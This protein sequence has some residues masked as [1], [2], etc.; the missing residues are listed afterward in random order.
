MIEVDIDDD[1]QIGRDLNPLKKPDARVREH[2]AEQPTDQS[3]RQAFQEQLAKQPHTAG[4]NREPDRDLARAGTPTGKQEI[5][6]IGARNDEHKTDQSHQKRHQNRIIRALLVAR[7]D[8]GLHR[9]VPAAIR[10]WILLLETLPDRRKLS[11]G[12]SH[13]R[14]ALDTRFHVG[15]V[16]SALSY[17]V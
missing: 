4:A 16:L 12:R 7:L 15:L 14:P 3:E 5:R 1:W 6:D 9:D 13:R 8:L 2:H 11:L 17:P 10:V